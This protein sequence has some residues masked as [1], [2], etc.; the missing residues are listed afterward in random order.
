MSFII[1]H[2]WIGFTHFSSYWVKYQWMEENYVSIQYLHLWANECGSVCDNN[3]EIVKKGN[4]HNLNDKKY[5]TI[6]FHKIDFL[7]VMYILI[8]KL[9]NI[10]PFNHTIVSC[11]GDRTKIVTARRQIIIFIGIKIYKCFKFL[12]LFISYQPYRLRIKF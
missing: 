10:K 12:K 9:L 2:P 11:F 7:L 6:I 3:L 5:I 8:V 4:A 1:I